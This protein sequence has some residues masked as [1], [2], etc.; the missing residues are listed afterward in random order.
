MS[1]LFSNCNMK[2]NKTSRYK[3]ALAIDILRGVENN[4]TEA[5]YRE[6]SRPTKVGKWETI[7]CSISS[8]VGF[9]VNAIYTF[10]LPAFFNLSNS[11]LLGAAFTLLSKWTNVLIKA[12][13]LKRIGLPSVSFPDMFVLASESERRE[14]ER[15]SVGRCYKRNLM[16]KVSVIHLR[17]NLMFLLQ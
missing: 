4:V 8:A 3:L 17:F 13:R 1:L 9:F 12:L 7:N 15:E 16:P 6:G 11:L 14:W 5:S 2:R 10:T